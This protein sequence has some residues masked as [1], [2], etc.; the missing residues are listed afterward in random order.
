MKLKARTLRGE[1]SLL[2]L[3]TISL[4]VILYSVMLDRYYDRGI[5]DA[6]EATMRLEART[7]ARAYQQDP[8]TPLPAS[9]VFS[10]AFN[11]EQLP[12]AAAKGFTE[13]PLEPGEFSEIIIEQPGSDS[14]DWHTKEI[15]ILLPQVLHDGRTLYLLGDY[16]LSLFTA[17]ELAKANQGGRNA[18]IVAGA[19]LLIVLLLLRML[20]R[21]I[22][23]EADALANWAE[24][25][26]LET[27]DQAP[28][29]FRYHELNRIALQLQQAF[30]RISQI[31]RREHH[32]LRHAS[33]EL[34]TPI[35]ITRSSLELIR[36]KGIDPALARPTERIERAN[37][38]MQQL[39]ET[40]L[41]LSRE[42]EAAPHWSQIDL[43]NFTQE[44][45][46][47]LS[48]LLSGKQVEWRLEGGAQRPQS[49]PATPL[50]IVLANLIR[51]AF[52][53]THEGEVV[54]S[55]SD[56]KI[57]VYNQDQSDSGDHN[58]DSFGL[59]LSLAQQICERLGWQL[60]VKPVPG[61]LTATLTLPQATNHD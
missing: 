10:A 40:L 5:D 35:A 36:R 43:N 17:E 58:E 20:R 25:L 38:N 22:S 33:H 34:R 27:R 30:D 9:S 29:D 26:D 57:Q 56:Q 14:D 32:F 51:N 55:V 44:L 19:V 45:A 49:Q 6:I 16:D 15:F 23:R 59:G 53:Y 13:T 41:W 42:N 12:E 3:G 7:F 28:P 1:L 48:Y 60:A 47:E 21:R 39:T 46:D 37:R 54:I 50:R 24:Q 4:L 8:A 18:M 31:L 11:L 52:Q 2:L 61:G